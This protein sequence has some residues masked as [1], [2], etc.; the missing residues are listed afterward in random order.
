[1]HRPT[2]C[3][4]GPDPL[5]TACKIAAVTG[6]ALIKYDTGA[7][8]KEQKVTDK[9]YLFVVG[10]PRSGTTALGLF[11]AQ[12]PAI[13]MGI[14]RFGHRAFKGNF[15]MVPE[16]F[17]SDRFCEFRKGDT[18]YPDFSFA[19]K[20]YENL[21]NKLTDAIWRGDKIPKM[22]QT[23]PELF[24]SF[25]AD[26]KVIFVFR[27]IFDVAASYKN[28]QDDQDDNW[29]LGVHT[30][31]ED[32]NSSISAYSTSSRK[33][34]IIPVIYEDFF[35]GPN[36]ARK[37]QDQLGVG[38]T[39]TERLISAMFQRSRTLESGRGRA[40]SQEDVMGISM[41]ANF[42]GF[43]TITQISREIFQ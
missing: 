8:S 3:L 33:D 36:I 29:N 39:D 1:M 10:C 31:I 2:Q 42:D 7:Q 21:E 5:G 30:A 6:A 13:L 18:F 43:R 14:E 37:L 4:G 15:S 23:L 34:D 24:K 9:K 25:D 32:W 16:L 40:L 22:F 12:N 26:I 38:N 35:S 11:L 17:E 28:R 20:A 19:P 27:N 41:K